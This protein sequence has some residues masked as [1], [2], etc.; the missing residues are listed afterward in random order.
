M[1]SNSTYNTSRAIPFL[2]IFL[3]TTLD[4]AIITYYQYYFNAS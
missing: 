4:G 1:K 3:V 2:I